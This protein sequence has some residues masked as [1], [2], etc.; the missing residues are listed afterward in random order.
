M[1]GA[2]CFESCDK[3][4]ERR[5]GKRLAETTLR[6]E[7]TRGVASY[8][9]TSSTLSGVMRLSIQQLGPCIESNI[10]KETK[11]QV[12]DETAGRCSR[13]CA[14]QSGPDGGLDNF[15]VYVSQSV[16]LF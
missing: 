2:S 5:F 1:E 8:V 7:A 3:S 14:Q 16:H 11:F 6:R 13:S 10:C 12:Q 15:Q 4:V 9:A